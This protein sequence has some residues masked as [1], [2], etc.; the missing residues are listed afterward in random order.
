MLLAD[1]FVFLVFIQNKLVAA[2]DEIT[3]AACLFP[4]FEKQH[5]G[6]ISFGAQK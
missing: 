6:N 4:D 2:D 3:I 5:A 1:N